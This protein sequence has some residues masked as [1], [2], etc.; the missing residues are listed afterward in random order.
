[1]RQIYPVSGSRRAASITSA[2]LTAI[3]ICSLAAFAEGQVTGPGGDAAAIPPTPQTSATPVAE[4]KKPENIKV[5]F[6][7]NQPGVVYIES[8]GE[9][10]KVD[11]NTKLVATVD[12][13]TA[14]TEVSS[15]A[16]AKTGTVAPK[17]TDDAGDSAYD[18]DKGEEPYSVRL[19]NLPTP[20]SMPKGTW[21]ME[22]THRFTQPIHPL[23]SSGRTL[24]GL[25]SFGIASFGM[26]YGVT[27]KLYVSAYRSPLCQRGLCRVIELGVGY[28]FLTQDK[29]S[30]IALSANAS[31]EGN[32]NFTEEYTY[33][34]QARLSGRIGKR[35]Y[36][37]FSPA[38]HINSNGQGRFNPRPT[39]YFPPAQIANEFKMSPHTGSFGFGA[40][41]LIRPDI[42]ATFEFTPRIGFKLG[43][44]SPVL[45]PNFNVVGF[46][47]RSQP[48]IGF[49]IQ[50]N[51]GKHS[52][53]LTFSNTQTTTTSRYNSSN[54][55]FSPR[56]LVIGF[57]LARRF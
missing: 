35:V 52:F 55:L 29:D 32:G 15:T 28:N 6:D 40:A 41:V 19:I 13:G 45:G 12:R 21:N 34:F 18:F 50:K 10:I 24:F 7:E 4:T 16:T 11:T 9:R 33:N 23:N 44:V 26:T 30:P 8:N 22:F 27:D 36:L 57:N 1:M 53:A 46:T 3:A 38:L 14:A 31:I 39:D 37:F 5:I 20:K 17:Q 54:L 25:D 48:E 2:L 56:K 51:I 47:N 49:G 43:R 42:V